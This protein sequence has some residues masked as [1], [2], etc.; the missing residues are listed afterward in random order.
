MSMH[1]AFT[2]MMLCLLAT[3]HV[4]GVPLLIFSIGVWVFAI[5]MF[6][7]AGETAYKFVFGIKR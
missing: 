5:G 3:F 4:D 1:E 6:L 2:K 7:I